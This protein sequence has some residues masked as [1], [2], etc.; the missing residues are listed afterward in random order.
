MGT[1][2]RQAS[3]AAC[4]RIALFANGV[5]ANEAGSDTEFALFAMNSQ[6]V[7]KPEEQSDSIA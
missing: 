2:H 4:V 5:G 7:A 6:Y 3:P 1:S